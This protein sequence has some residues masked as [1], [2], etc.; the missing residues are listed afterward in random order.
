[1]RFPDTILDHNRHRVFGRVLDCFCDL[2]SNAAFVTN[3]VAGIADTASWCS[4]ILAWCRSSYCGL[5]CKCWHAFVCIVSVFVTVHVG[6]IAVRIGAD[7]ATSSDFPT[8]PIAATLASFI[9]AVLAFVTAALAYASAVIAAPTAVLAR[10]IAFFVAAAAFVLATLRSAR[11]RR[12][13][14]R[15]CV[16][17]A[18]SAIVAYFDTSCE[19]KSANCNIVFAL[20]TASPTRS[21]DIATPVAAVTRPSP[22]QAASDQ[23]IVAW[24]RSPDGYRCQAVY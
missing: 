1:M 13:V 19:T 22:Q 18:A 10:S 3:G 7:F 9:T 8:C 11:A 12:L 24:A 4:A 5:Q 17:L 23:R 6:I 15:V 16:V 20:V 21:I 2:V 14:L